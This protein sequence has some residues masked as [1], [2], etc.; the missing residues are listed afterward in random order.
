MQKTFVK[1]RTLTSV[2]ILAAV[3]ALALVL[4]F[5]VRGKA[6]EPGEI[7]NFSYQTLS[8]LDLAGDADT[9]LRFLFTVGSLSYNEV[10]F[11]FSKTNQLP[12]VG[13]YGCGKKATTTVYSTVT[14]NGTPEAAPD[15]R[16]WVAVKMTDIPHE[17]FDGALY[18]RPYVQDGSG[19][20]YGE[21]KSI[22][23]CSA[24][25]HV[26]DSQLFPGCE[27]CELEDAKA[28]V[29]F[30][31]SS[32]KDS[33][34]WNVSDTYKNIR[35]TG[36][37]R[38]HSSNGNLGNDLLIE[39]SI[40]WNESL[41][42]GEGSALDIGVGDGS[43]IANVYL[44]GVNA[45]K[46]VA[47]ERAG[48]TYIYPTP[49]AIAENPSLKTVSLGEYGWHR[50]GFRVHQ[51][52]AIVNAAVKYTY[53]I[54]VYLDGEMVLKYDSST[55]ATSTSGARLFNATI[56]NEE[57][58]YSN[59]DA[60]SSKANTTIVD[61]Y[62]G[63]KTYLPIA[64]EYMTCGK[65][66]VQD[67]VRDDLPE[68]AKLA[69][70][71]EDDLPAERWFELKGWKNETLLNSNSSDKPN[72]NKWQV[73]KTYKS[74]C[75]NN[76]EKYYPDESNGN[77]GNDLLIE[78]S[79]LWNESLA[80]CAGSAIDIGVNDE[81]DIANIYLTGVNAGKI[82]AK[83]RTGTTYIYP[84]PAAIAENASLKT[85]SLGDYGWHRIGVRVHQAAAKV[86]ASVQYTYIITI[87][88]DGEMVL[89]YDSSA[90]A[91]STS[92]ARLFNATIENGNLKYSPNDSNSNWASVTIVN[93]YAGSDTDLAIADQYM[94]CG[95]EFVQDVVKVVD[96]VARTT[97]LG[98]TDYSSK[99]WYQRQIW[100]NKTIL[101]SSDKGSGDWDVRPTF[102]S[103]R[104][105]E[106]FYPDPSNG[107]RGNDLLIEFSIL[108]NDTMA[109][110]Y[111]S[112]STFDIGV[113]DGSDIANIDLQSATSGKFSA[114]ER[115]GTTYLYPTDPEARHPNIG[116]NGWHRV[117]VRVHQEAAIVAD[118][119]QYTYIITIYLDGEM[120]LQYDSS[121]W[122]T[123]NPGALL[124]TATNDGG[125]LVYA[126]NAAGTAKANIT[127]VNYYKGSNNFLV[128]ADEYMTCGREFVRQVKPVAH[129][130]AATL[131]PL[132]GVGL[133]A[134]AW[135]A[136]ASGPIPAENYT[137]TGFRSSDYLT[138]LSY[139]V[140]KYD[141]GWDGRDPAEAIQ[142]ILDASP[143]IAGLQEVNANWN[144]NLAT[145]TSNGYARIQGD[146]TTDNW[147]ELFYKTARFTK[148]NSGY[149]RYSAL[150]SEFPGV[151]KNGADTSRDNQGRLFTWA[152][153]EDNET[154]KVVL[155]ISTHL[156]YRVD[157]YDNA[158]SDEN[159]LLRRYEIRLLLAWLKAQVFEYDAVV[160]VG[161]VNEHYPSSK[162]R[163]TTDLFRES[164][165][166]V[167]RDVAAIKGDVGS[168]L[169]R[170][171]RTERD[172][173]VFDL[174]LL[175][176]NVEAT[177]YTAVDNKTDKLGTSYPSDHVPILTEIRFR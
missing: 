138:V 151:P 139:N 58:K 74:I 37:F 131:S 161:D 53:I 143:D 75:G 153:L 133:R 163:A 4:L 46:I 82:V 3:A 12:T 69:L 47:K 61:F 9:D 111:G 15:G 76:T 137:H 175:R 73:R 170:S 141:G 86:D 104:D 71:G 32:D 107:N 29:D 90:W 128:I 135:Y 80:D 65:E 156:H 11:V 171:G 168:T 27:G 8:A 91:N 63:T 110:V 158:S 25:K 121:A 88:L 162:G 19:V 149:K 108:W 51:E 59:N 103:I 6:D 129:P 20:R 10:G 114:K 132:A 50:L 122:A 124:F 77:L 155:A 145:L 147:P 99:L 87:Y 45:G 165:F 98:G 35:G 16:W 134:E 36:Y 70:S 95:K 43:D 81:S 160:I 42:D 177:Y 52:A 126:D 159:T 118:A 83:E 67:V 100:D 167:A 116:A 84:T 93:F 172:N 176:G 79:I 105:G 117:G 5:T 13:G 85:V 106:H 136:R 78:F 64:D 44:T 157:E 140:E 120:I 18:V 24:A 142:T 164:G 174:I 150:A 62:A 154:G 30:Y 14:A 130:T 144:G 34:N 28:D 57:L 17:Y 115:T 166:G 68:A 56:E 123:A 31:N 39:F 109:T 125:N 26:H 127:I 33:G 102:N 113:N 22:T 152:R 97:T 21:A 40:L 89:K 38:P 92:G 2:L 41:T 148:L 146:T 60:G 94:T 72:N 96:P 119:V 1:P 112:G 173:Y 49:A 54:T 48:T 66:F 23:V 7:A 55:W 101:N 169:T